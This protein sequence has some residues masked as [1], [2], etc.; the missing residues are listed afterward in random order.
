MLLGL[1]NP[2]HYVQDYGY[3]AIFILSVLQSMCVPTSSELT[4]GFAGVMAGEGKLNLP[5]AIAAG[6]AGEVVG[7]LIAWYI[8]RT[9]G[10]GF[11]DKFGKYILLTHH[12]LDKAEAWYGR[13]ERWGVFGSRLLPVIRNF[14]AVPAGVAEVPIVRFGILTAAG[15]LI[16]LSAM[17][18]IGYNVAGSWQSV[19]KGFSDAGYV[20]GALVVA[21]IAF[22]IWHRWRS[23]KKH[24]SPGANARS[25]R[26]RSDGNRSTGGAGANA[27][28]GASGRVGAGARRRD[29]GN[30]ARR[31]AGSGVRRDAASG[32]RRGNAGAHDR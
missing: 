9:L 17:A 31:G 32:S 13:H 2:T 5:G 4:L 16:W 22:V 24:S 28:L 1:F 14:V 19:M 15:S 23:Y 10:R 29:S 25:S 7:A 6:V 8:G 26:P 18:L 3:L 20:L 30:G 21:A 11:V 27:R 12:D